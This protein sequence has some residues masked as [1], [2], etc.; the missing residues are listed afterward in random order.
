MIL[1]RHGAR[2]AEKLCCLINKTIYTKLINSRFLNKKQQNSRIS[3]VLAKVAASDLSPQ[4]ELNPEIPDKNP[5]PRLTSLP[6]TSTAVTPSFVYHRR[7]PRPC[8][9]LVVEMPQRYSMNFR[10]ELADGGQN[11]GHRI[12]VYMVYL[13]TWL[14]DFFWGKLGGTYNTLYIPYMHP[15]SKEWM[16]GFET[17]FGPIGFYW[18]MV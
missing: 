18:M 10:K 11:P 16:G 14:V 4:L 3:S 15:M 1:S 6:P 13:P 17:I 2:C 7:L 5:H 8:G 9:S 12:H